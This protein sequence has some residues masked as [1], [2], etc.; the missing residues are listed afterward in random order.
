MLVVM[1]SGVVSMRLTPEPK[2]NG[3]SIGRVSARRADGYRF[4]SCPFHRNGSH[5]TIWR[6][7]S[8]NGVV[9]KV[10]YAVD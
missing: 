9:A 7:G 2:W 3:N 5:Y 4:K 10:V 8:A 1:P 6:V